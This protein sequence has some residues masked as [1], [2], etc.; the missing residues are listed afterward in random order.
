MTPATGDC[1]SA[2]LGA[3]GATASFTV[4]NTG[5]TTTGTVSVSSN[6]AQFHGGRVRADVGAERHLHLD[7][8]VQG[9]HAR[10]ATRPNQGGLARANASPANR[11]GVG[12]GAGA[13]D[14]LNLAVALHV[15]GRA[16]VGGRDADIHG[17]QRRRRR[18]QRAH[19]V[20]RHGHKRVGVAQS[21]AS[22]RRQPAHADARGLQREFKSAS[23]T[24]AHSGS[25]A[26]RDASSTL[27][28]DALSGGGT[29]I[30]VREL[31]SDAIS[32]SLQS[33]WASDARLGGRRRSSRVRARQRGHVDVAN[34]ELRRTAELHVHYRH[35]C[36]RGSSSGG[37]YRSTGDGAWNLFGTGANVTTGGIFAFNANDVWVMTT[38]TSG[39]LAPTTC[40][41][42]RRGAIRRPGQQNEMAKQGCQAM[43]GVSRISIAPISQREL[44]VVRARVGIAHRDA[45]GTWAVSD[46]IGSTTVAGRH[47]TIWGTSGSDLYFR[48]VERTGRCTTT[49]RRGRR[50][51]LR[52]RWAFQRHL[53]GER[54]QR[55]LRRAVRHRAGRRIHLGRGV[56][57]E[58]AV[59][60]GRLRNRSQ[61]HLRRRQRQ[62][63]TCASVSLVLTG[64]STES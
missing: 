58:L 35:R 7:R 53:G 17:H 16:A 19:R 54:H 31:S 21:P 13:G 4:K 32:G 52:R 25:L 2:L 36:D 20:D 5:Q 34:D 24:G 62:R 39:K 40:R 6:D 56:P 48:R 43:W 57:A 49:A 60:D 29:P 47:V 8:D 23:F 51:I 45:T 37:Y 44:G 26:I 12:R 15:P 55:L 1:G 3:T 11:V 42:P 27:K 22:A 9:E 59:G 30:W 33:V 14:A 41:R 61:R 10:H 46:A 50:S 63:R 18:D 38:M 64:R 28:T